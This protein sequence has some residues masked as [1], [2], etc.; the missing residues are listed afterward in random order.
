MAVG[1]V[2]GVTAATI[3]KVSGVARPNIKKVSGVDLYSPVSL[4]FKYL[5]WAGGPAFAATNPTNNTAITTWPDEMGL[6]NCTAV[7]A[8]N[9]TRQNT[10]GPNNQTSVLFD[11][12]DNMTGTL[13][14]GGSSGFSVVAVAKFTAADRAVIGNT[15][16]N[17]YL[18]TNGTDWVFEGG[19]LGGCGGHVTAIDTNYHLFTGISTTTRYTMEVDGVVQQANQSGGTP[20][21]L[22]VTYLGTFG[23]NYYYYQTY[24]PLIGIYDGGDVRDASGWQQFED[25]CETQFSLTIA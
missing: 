2:A 13:S 16:G 8:S 25:W 15:D 9:P 24:T 11:S 7:G 4:G 12:N 19:N 21:T 22:G 3:S 17:L 14:G 23:P 18:Y 5:Y 6:V 1:K 10:G 20:R